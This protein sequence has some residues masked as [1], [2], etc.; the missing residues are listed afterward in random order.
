ML[1][2][3]RW[4]GGP[5]YVGCG[6]M[7]M[8]IL[9]CVSWSTQCVCIRTCTYMYVRVRGRD[10]AWVHREGVV[11]LVCMY[12]YV[13]CTYVGRCVR[14]F[15]CT[16]CMYTFH[17]HP[18]ALQAAMNEK[19]PV[20][21][22]VNDAGSDL[23]KAALPTDVDYVQDKLDKLNTTFGALDTALQQRRAFLQDTLGLATAYLA[24]REEAERAIAEK[25]VEVSALPPV[26][27]DIE[28]V[29]TQLE[30]C[31]VRVEGWSAGV[32]MEAVR[33]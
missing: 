15:V 1:Y 7:H 23:C 26:G 32:S 27:M 30:E 28:T 5:V 2:I 21:Q 8:Y 14:S 20:V 33:E 4:K 24:A 31:K 6:Y 9:H 10:T 3:R 11:F 18:Q 13:G 25:Q 19:R 17:F 16:V 22:A 29:Q 12:A